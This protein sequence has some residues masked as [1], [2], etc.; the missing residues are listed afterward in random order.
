MTT[1]LL[2]KV[3]KSKCFHVS[4][5]SVKRGDSDDIDSMANISKIISGKDY[6]LEALP[7]IGAG[8]SMEA[9]MI[10]GWRPE[11]IVISGAPIPLNYNYETIQLPL[12]P[13]TGK[14]QIPLF[15]GPRFHN[16]LE[17]HKSF[18]NKACITE[19]PTA[20]KINKKGHKDT[21]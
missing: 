3:S 16:S 11:N 21:Y 2:K 15:L 1:H 17:V 13:E 10:F 7:L 9:D 20:I 6:E 14:E 4:V 5:V 18:A 8:H 19:C 12:D